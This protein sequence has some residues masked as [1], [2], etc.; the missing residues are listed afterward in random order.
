MVREDGLNLFIN[1]AGYISG[2]TLHEL[3]S[4]QMRHNYEVNC[5]AP[6]ML[7]KVGLV[8]SCIYPVLQ[9][10]SIHTLVGCN[11]CIFL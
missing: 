1:N 10:N 5:I 11:Y 2:Q 4:E 8:L 3:T 7:T 9:R 6:L